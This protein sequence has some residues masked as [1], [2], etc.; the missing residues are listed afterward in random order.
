[1]FNDIMI[2]FQS[3][4]DIRPGFSY[5]TLALFY[6]RALFPHWVQAKLSIDKW[7]TIFD[8]KR[9]KQLDLDP[10][11]Q[12]QRGVTINRRCYGKSVKGSMVRDQENTIR[13]YT[14]HI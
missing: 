10:G 8:P 6:G 4:C 3:T 9:K 1:M 14:Q 5:P 12:E 13:P 11:A 7:T 2:S